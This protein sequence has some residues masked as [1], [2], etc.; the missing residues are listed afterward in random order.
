MLLRETPHQKSCLKRSLTGM[1]ASVTSRFVICSCW[2]V[3]GR[4][5]RG[6]CAN[7]GQSGVDYE[8]PTTA[9]LSSKVKSPSRV[10]AYTSNA[11]S[12]T[13]FRLLL[14]PDSSGPTI[15]GEGAQWGL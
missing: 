1:A 8:S 12:P 11:T 10:L 2:E 7:P 5:E 3:C 6:S 13:A 9:K 14:P 4:G 15:G